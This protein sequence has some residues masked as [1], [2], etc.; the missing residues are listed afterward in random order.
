MPYRDAKKIAQASIVWVFQALG[1]AD[2]DYPRNAG[3]DPCGRVAEALQGVF[4]GALLITLAGGCWR[5]SGVDCVGFET[6][7]CWGER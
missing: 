5:L 6:I 4:L 7:I 3:S 2:R 1:S